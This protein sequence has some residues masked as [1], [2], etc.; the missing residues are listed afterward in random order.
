MCSDVMQEPSAIARDIAS[1]ALCSVYSEQ[2]LA[3]WSRQ[4]VWVECT[5]IR[6]KGQLQ[7]QPDRL[8]SSVR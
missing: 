8:A 3:A 2:S 7:T 4:D 5:R 1:N 6:Q